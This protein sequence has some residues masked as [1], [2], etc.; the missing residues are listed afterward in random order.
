MI[1]S[2]KPF[3]SSLYSMNLVKRLF[4]LL[5]RLFYVWRIKL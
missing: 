1:M 2:G 5:E 4:Y 3:T